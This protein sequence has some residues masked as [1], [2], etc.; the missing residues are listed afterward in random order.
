MA[1]LNQFDP[2]GQLGDFDAKG[3]AAWSEFLNFAFDGNVQEVE[4]D[5]GAGRSPFYNPRRTATVEPVAT[6]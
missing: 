1:T 4:K 5:V 6:K 2:P 3:H